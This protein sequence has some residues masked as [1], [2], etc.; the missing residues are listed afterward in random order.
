MLFSLEKY[1]MYE[2]R[3]EPEI[4][5]YALL[6]PDIT[7]NL[8]IEPWRQFADGTQFFIT[9][10]QYIISIN[11]SLYYNIF[12]YSIRLSGPSPRLLESAIR[13][14]ENTIYGIRMTTLP[15]LIRH[16]N[17]CPGLIM[18]ESSLVKFCSVCYTSFTL[19]N[20]Y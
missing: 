16:N 20:K 2:R 9:F 14:S 1:G 12:G 13:S 6:N 15:E 8:T 17:T 18:R 3:I 19:V 11:Y 5:H 10:K 7:L 4:L